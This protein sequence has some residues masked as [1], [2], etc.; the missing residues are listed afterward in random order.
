MNIDAV[1]FDCDGVLVDSEPITN[2]VLQ[3]MLAQLGWHM[4]TQ[5]CFATFV[6][7][8]IL[9]Q[10][11]LIKERTGKLVTDEWLAL[12]RQK[13]DEALLAKLR[14]IPHIHDT[15]STLH[16]A[17]QGRIAVASGADHGKVI[18]QLAKVGLLAQFEGRTFSGME[19]PRNKPHPDVYLAAAQ[20]L[21]VPIA[22]CAVIEDTANGARAGVVAG[23]VVFGYV[24]AGG[25]SNNVAALEAVGVTKFFDNMRDLPSLLALSARDLG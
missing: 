15:V 10:A 9:D 21:G 20:V 17:T 1:L 6:G 12:F 22:R 16:A 24:P 23:A 7:H 4:T 5:E 8:A 3:V 13:R 11:P 25:L 14:A 2:G 19:Q 18:L